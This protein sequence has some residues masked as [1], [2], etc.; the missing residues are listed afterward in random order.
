MKIKVT[1]VIATARQLSYIYVEKI[2][3]TLFIDQRYGENSILQIDWKVRRNV[4]KIDLDL[5]S[6]KTTPLKAGSI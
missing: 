6:L 5:T 2:K 1:A 3:V 4:A